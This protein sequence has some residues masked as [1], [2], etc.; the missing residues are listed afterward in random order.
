MCG[1]QRNDVAG[2]AD[3]ALAA[4]RPSAQPSMPERAE[5]MTQLATTLA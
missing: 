2:V 4:T 5:I 3:G 1:T